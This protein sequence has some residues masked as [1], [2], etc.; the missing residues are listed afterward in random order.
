M[1]YSTI[2]NDQ[3]YF[4]EGLLVRISPRRKVLH[5]AFT[6][7][8]G[9]V[10][11]ASFDYGPPRIVEIDG[12]SLTQ[13]SSTSLS[14]G[15]WYWASNVLYVRKSDSNAPNSGDFIVVTYDLFMADQD[16]QWYRTPTDSATS[17]EAWSPYLKKFPQIKQTVSDVLSGFV[18]ITVDSIELDNSEHWIERHLDG[19]FYKAEVKGWHYVDSFTVA[20]T[21]LL[22]E[23]LVESIS[24]S[25]NSVSFG[26]T[27]IYEVF[28]QEYRSGTTTASDFYNITEF[29]NV[30]SSFVGKPKRSVFGYCEG[31]KC[32][33]LDFSENN[34][35]TDN[36]NWAIMDRAETYSGDYGFILMNDNVS[37]TSGNDV[38]FIDADYTRHFQV[39]DRIYF[40]NGFSYVGERFVTAV[41][42][43]SITCN[44]SMAG[45]TN[46]A[47]DYLYRGQ[48]PRIRIEQN[49]TIYTARWLKHYEID[50]STDVIYANFLSGYSAN[51][52]MSP[53]K[54]SDQ[55][56]AD[57]YGITYSSN[58]DSLYNVMVNPISILQ[59]LFVE[60]IGI[61]SGDLS[62]N[63]ATLKSSITERLS[64]TVPKNVNDDY[65]T[66]KDLIGEICLS[67]RLRIFKNNDNEWDI[68]QIEAIG[69][70]VDT[71]TDEDLIDG[72]FSADFS[73]ADTLSDVFVEFNR[74]E[75]GLLAG[76]N[77]EEY[78]TVSAQSE[79]AKF[80]HKVEKQKTF[81]TLH[82][83]E[84]D[85]QSAANF[86][87]NYFGQ[88]KGTYKARLAKRFLDSLIADEVT[89]SRDKMPSF[90]YLEGVLRS[91]DL[92]ITEINK[93]PNSINLIFDDQ[94]GI[95]DNA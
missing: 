58:N 61:D 45:W 14:A 73:Y 74:K 68:K 88:R 72:T 90:D 80:L 67:S 64:F 34:T 47:G 44:A 69:T 94:Q 49:D 46:V 79:T 18:P 29:P 93:S 41:N 15:Q 95:E 62:A 66:F 54:N 9:S 8:S 10:Y 87:R 65:P 1:T 25:Q 37:S 5:S 2:L 77:D 82:L 17:L 28:N 48:I 63:W 57:V 86:L 33:N 78:E 55:V 35:E 84:A 27:D 52:G 59:Y 43:S 21:T 4:E 71:A 26:I 75:R 6:L 13:G 23:G 22:L 89:I 19:S 91:K 3:D 16:Y 30:D 7:F 36:Q 11:S 76:E 32:V 60:G 92:V 24:Y 81:K 20:N 40:V 53:I 38:N 50:F 39:G 56:F 12:V 85:A 31:V 83:E 51:L 42:A 70:P